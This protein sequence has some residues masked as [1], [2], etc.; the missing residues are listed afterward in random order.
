MDR[1]L[2]GSQS[3]SWRGA[4]RIISVSVGNETLDVQLKLE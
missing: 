2:Y 4:R 1:K 3:R